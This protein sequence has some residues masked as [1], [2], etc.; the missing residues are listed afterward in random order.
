MCF[1]TAFFFLFFDTHLSSRL[2]RATAQ[3]ES[4]GLTK[5]LIQWTLAWDTCSILYVV[6]GLIS[7][8][9]LPFNVLFHNS[10]LLHARIEC[11]DAMCECAFFLSLFNWKMPHT[12]TEY[13]FRSLRAVVGGT[14]FRC[15]ICFKFC[16]AFK[17]RVN[18][19]SIW[20]TFIFLRSY[21]WMK[22]CSYFQMV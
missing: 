21:W 4:W 22:L 12:S 17:S 7:C 9:K 8:N 5:E 11:V 14:L 1:T 10:P 20:V 16:V 3:H 19:N 15:E 13:Y 18:E 6:F 2:L